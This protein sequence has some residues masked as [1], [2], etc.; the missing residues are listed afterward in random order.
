MKIL[1]VNGVKYGDEAMSQAVLK[2]GTID[3]IVTYKEDVRNVKLI[4]GG[5]LRIPH[6]ERIPS[7]TDRLT[8]LLQPLAK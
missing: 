4:Y 3:L 6:L 2:G 1:S 5:G 7:T 8:D